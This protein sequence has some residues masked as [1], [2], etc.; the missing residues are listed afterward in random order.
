MPFPFPFRFSRDLALLHN[1]FRS[2]NLPIPHSGE[3]W[4]QDNLI[5]AAASLINAAIFAG[6]PHE[7]YLPEQL[8]KSSGEVGDAI[9]D[10]HQ[11]QV[12]ATLALFLDL[13]QRT[14]NGYGDTE[15]YDAAFHPVVTGQAE[16]E[17]EQSGM[18]VFLRG[19]L[20]ALEQGPREAAEEGSESCSADT[21]DDEVSR[22]LAD[23]DSWKHT[24]DDEARQGENRAAHGIHSAHASDDAQRIL[25]IFR[26]LPAPSSRVQ[27]SIAERA[28]SEKKRSFSM[29]SS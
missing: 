3:G 9:F 25:A 26:P 6:P 4:T 22:L 12:M 20:A 8:A 16:L 14:D 2:R 5:Q 10:R 18:N 19:D 13:T 11:R 29:Y 24:G 28:K 17:V 23:P 1:H 27:V 21:G 7:C 15:K